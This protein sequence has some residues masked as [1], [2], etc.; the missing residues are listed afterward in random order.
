MCVRAD[1]WCV[2]SVYRKWPNYIPLEHDSVD[3][4]VKVYI[5]LITQFIYKIVFASDNDQFL[6]S[7][8]NMQTS[9]TRKQSKAA[10][11]KLKHKSSS[12][13]KTKYIWIGFILLCVC[14]SHSLHWL[15]ARPDMQIL[16]FNLSSQMQQPLAFSEYKCFM[17]SNL[18]RSIWR[19]DPVAANSS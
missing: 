10:K 11:S 18:I 5:D 14:G 3:I 2:F 12:K 6:R 16:K 1:C 17:R 13:I 15:D 7:T 4:N 19:D 9:Y 8:Q